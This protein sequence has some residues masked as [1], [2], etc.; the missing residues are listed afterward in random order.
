[1]VL[2]RPGSPIIRAVF[3][4]KAMVSLSGNNLMHAKWHWYFYVPTWEF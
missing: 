4:L 3:C 2:A 1:M